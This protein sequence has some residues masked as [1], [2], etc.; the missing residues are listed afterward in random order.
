MVAQVFLGTIEKFICFLLRLTHENNLSFL[1]NY[2]SLRK[3]DSKRKSKASLQVALSSNEHTNFFIHPSHVMKS[4]FLIHPPFLSIPTKFFHSLTLC[5]HIKILPNSS[6]LLLV[7][8][9][10]VLNQ[11]LFVPNQIWKKIN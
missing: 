4:N 5:D 8:Y 3:Q 6:T 2:N 9:G 10:L 1:V 11:H 7:T